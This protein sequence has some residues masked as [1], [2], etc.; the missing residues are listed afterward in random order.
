MRLAKL[1]TGWR[2]LYRDGTH[3]ACIDG[4]K[5]IIHLT[6]DT[7]YRKSASTVTSL[8]LVTHYIL[9]PEESLASTIEGDLWMQDICMQLFGV[10]L[11]LGYAELDGADGFISGAIIA[12][13]TMKSVLNCTFCVT[14]LIGSA[15]NSTLK[16]KFKSK[17]HKNTAPP[18]K[19]ADYN[20][21]KLKNSST[22]A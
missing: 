22:H 5:L 20:F 6:A 18:T 10:K 14:K 1:P 15:G 3:G 13:K 11:E 4:S 2:V 16:K 7:K 21:V 17:G 9:S 19:L 12:W 8:P